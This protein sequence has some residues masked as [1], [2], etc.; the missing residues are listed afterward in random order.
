MY[1]D[2]SRAGGQGGYDL[3]VCKRAS[4]EDDWGPPENLGPTVN[5]ASNETCA[6]IT[7]DGLELYFTPTGPEGTAA[8]ISM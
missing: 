6:S 3:W 1:I 7:A 4:P 5:S 2:S 8:T